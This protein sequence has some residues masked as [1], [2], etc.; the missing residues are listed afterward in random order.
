[1]KI[2]LL[3][4]AGL[5]ALLVIEASAA[6]S[7]ARA[8]SPAESV[9]TAHAATSTAPDRDPARTKTGLKGANAA[10][11]AAPR[12]AAEH[13]R[14]NADRLHSPRARVAKSTSQPIVPKHAAATALTASARTQLDAHP[15]VPPKLSVS[16][17]AVR[18]LPNLNTVPRGS[19]IGGPHVVGPGRIGGPATGRAA[20][21]AGIN[22]TPLHRKF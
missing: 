2:A 11:T 14:S 1:M 9:R 13:T 20:N 3:L 12:N 8:D 6:G 19:I 16:R 15:L 7:P 17:N 4:C 18:A 22:G 10:V 21:S 5:W